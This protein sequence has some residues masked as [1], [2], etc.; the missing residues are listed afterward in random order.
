MDKPR[1]VEEWAE[2]CRHAIPS[3]I[4]AVKLCLHCARAYAA[5]Q[6]A[7]ELEAAYREAAPYTDKMRF[8]HRMVEQARAEERKRAVAYLR[9]LQGSHPHLLEAYRHA[10]VNLQAALDTDWHPTEP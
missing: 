10:E 5:E 1:S 3:T 2:L 4:P 7:Q 9:V 6:V 8:T